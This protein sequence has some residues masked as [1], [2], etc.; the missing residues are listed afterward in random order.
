MMTSP[1]ASH[2]GPRAKHLARQLM[3]RRTKVLALQQSALR[4][5]LLVPRPVRSRVEVNVAPVG[6]VRPFGLDWGNAGPGQ[7]RPAVQRSTRDAVWAEADSV[8]AGS[9]EGGT[10]E[11]VVPAAA[12]YAR[13]PEVGGV[14]K[15]ATA[16]R[17]PAAVQ[18]RLRP[19]LGDG[20][21]DVVV[22]TGE[23][24]SALPRGADA[25]TVGTDVYW[26]DGSPATDHAGDA[27]LLRHEV[28]H[29]VQSTRPGTS[30]RRST[31]AGREAEERQA[32]AY[33]QAVD[34]P[35]GLSPTMG[36]AG[37]PDGDLLE[38]TRPPTR[39]QPAPQTWST[40]TGPTG[41]PGR[42]APDRQP[43]PGVRDPQPPALPG[44]ATPPPRVISPEAMYQEV[45]RQLRRDKERG[46]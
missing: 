17:L 28:W 27:E 22:H 25:V 33:A 10:R 37:A 4:E 15:Q 14:F 23:T 36:F 11:S 6:E 29:A 41:V 2:L 30:W 24:A 39:P 1:P 44:Q 16:G 8:S 7:S 20:V 32:G 13:E 35:I 34:L 21:R 45:L 9:R 19:T 3:A 18:D 26:A 31:P 43:M 12:S 5:R 38:P 40:P 42:A 46:A